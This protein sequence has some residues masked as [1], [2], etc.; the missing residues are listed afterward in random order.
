M[1][2][3]N[4]AFPYEIQVTAHER[5]TLGSTHLATIS[6]ARDGRAYVWANGRFDRFA[7]DP[8][9]VSFEDPLPLIIQA[10]SIAMRMASR[11]Q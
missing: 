6:V 9:P 3:P 11:Q 5:N 8:A 7:I 10:I 2:K 1:A 4:P